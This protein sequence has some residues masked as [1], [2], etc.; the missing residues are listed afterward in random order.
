MDKRKL[1]IFLAV[2]EA[3]SFNR[4]A[5]SLHIA[6]SAVSVAIQKLEAHLGVL[7]F[8][9]TDRQIRLTVEGEELRKHARTIVN[10]FADAEQAMVNL[11]QLEAGTVRFSTTAMLGQV[12]FPTIIQQFRAR[13]PNIDF[14]I[15]GEGTASVDGL[16]ADG[17]ISM[18]VVNMDKPVPGIAQQLLVDTE[19]VMC[20]AADHPL[21]R[22]SAISR[23][24]F[25]EQSLVIYQQD[26]YLRELA[27]RLHREAKKAPQVGIETDQLGMILALVRQQQGVTL[28][29]DLLTK[30]S[31]DLVGI[32]F[33]QPHRLRLGMGWSADRPLSVANQAFLDHLKTHGY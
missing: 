20:V 1:Q 25:C 12:F 33:T 17:E 15:R 14:R 2:A 27:L 11:H 21:A 23:A 29:L 31:D 24:R 7:L 5:Q 9:R 18:G 4:A 30:Q 6:Q 16:I 26:Y 19:I 22:E 3:Q 32:P 13:Y 10:Q 8:D 28:A